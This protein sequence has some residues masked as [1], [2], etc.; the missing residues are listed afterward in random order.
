MEGPHQEIQ[1]KKG[2]TIEAEIATAIKQTKRNWDPGQDQITADMLKA[3]PTLSAG[4][5]SKAL[6]SSLE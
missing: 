3:D 5:A 6:Q 1:M 2:R 4:F